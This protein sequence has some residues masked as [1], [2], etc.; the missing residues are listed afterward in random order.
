MRDRRDH[1]LLSHHVLVKVSR[2]LNAHLMIGNLSRALKKSAAEH[3][4]RAVLS[5]E[6]VYYF[7]D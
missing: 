7:C 1:S 3:S 6:K 5:L 4:S 2:I